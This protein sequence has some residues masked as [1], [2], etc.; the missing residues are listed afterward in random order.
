MLSLF[1]GIGGIWAALSRLGIP[2]VGY[3]SEVSDP[4]IQVVK[5]KFPEVRHVGDVRRLARPAIPE[6][7]DLIVGG[8]PCQDLSCLGKREGLHGSRS[9]LF[10]DLVGVLKDF[11]PRWFLVENV[12]SMTWVDRD[13]ISKYLGVQPIELDSIELSPTRRKRLYW[14]NIPH[15]TRLPRVKDHP[16]TFVQSCLHDAIALEEKTGERG[17]L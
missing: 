12:A 17:K 3:S 2:F 14:T 7:I 8:F 16:S 10:F 6:D 11:E 5:A 13:E 4:A 1:D 15:P 9:K